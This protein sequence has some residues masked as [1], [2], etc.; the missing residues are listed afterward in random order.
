MT[1][2]S[3]GKT[4]PEKLLH[5]D[6]EQPANPQPGGSPL[7]YWKF[8]LVRHSCAVL[9]LF[10]KEICYLSFKTEYKVKLCN[11]KKEKNTQRMLKWI[12][13]KMDINLRI[14]NKSLKKI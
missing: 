6:S 4:I 5:R 9:A 12:L 3:N 7:C 8:S 11:I 10:Y 2:S 14:Q 1:P 13:V